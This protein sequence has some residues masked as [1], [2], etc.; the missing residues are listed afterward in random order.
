[1][2]SGSQSRQDTKQV[3]A[4]N[5]A[6]WISARL[7]AHCTASTLGRM[8]CRMCLLP[9]DVCIICLHD[10]GATTG[11]GVSEQGLAGLKFG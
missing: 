3:R 4:S 6:H 10:R 5:F 7:V 2:G 1:M 11:N 8:L 9:T